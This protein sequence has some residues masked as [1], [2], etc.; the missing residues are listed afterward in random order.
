MRQED[1]TLSICEIVTCITRI[2]SLERNPAVIAKAHNC[3]D[4]S[5]ELISGRRDIGNLSDIAFMEG[6]GIG[7]V[8]RYDLSQKFTM[9]I[10]RAESPVEMFFHN[11][12]IFS[13]YAFM[14]DKKRLMISSW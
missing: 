9:N 2:R 13:R 11:Y 14:A 5:V 7:S 3:N 4:S 12:P 6:R 8:G 10:K 1:Y